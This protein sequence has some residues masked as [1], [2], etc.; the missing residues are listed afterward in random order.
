[1]GIDVRAETEN[2]RLIEEVLDYQGLT[3][4]L[5]PHCA[6]ASWICLRFVDMYGDTVFNQLQIALLIDELRRVH[7]D[8]N[9]PATQEH[10]LAIL[11]L[12]ESVEG[13]VHSYVRFVGD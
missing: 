2:R 1:M 5:L 8:L 4:R 11:R 6:D 10:A 7:D 9:D 12:V 13:R 3:K